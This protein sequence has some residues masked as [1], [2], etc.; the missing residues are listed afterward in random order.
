[1]GKGRPMSKK[2]VVNDA[3]F[4]FAQQLI[5]QGRVNKD[6]DNWMANEPTP[7][8]EDL[9]LA[10]HSFDEYGRWF[11]A[12]D[13]AASEDTKDRY[14][15]PIGNFHE[16]FRSGVLAA[17]KRAGQYKHEEIEDAAKA[18]LSLIDK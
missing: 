17:E 4:S 8:S 16:I 9:F 15:F 14:E 3:A 10:D 13:E 18:L 12:I 7:E 5:K 6:R 1:M 11:L 2:L